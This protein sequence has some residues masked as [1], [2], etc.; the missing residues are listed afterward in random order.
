LRHAIRPR[1]TTIKNPQAN[2]ICERMHQA[3]GNSLRVLSTMQPP[4]GINAARDLVDIALADALF[5]T[6]ASLHGALK[7]TPGSIAF[8]R[9]MVLDIPFIADLQYLQ[10]H[11]QQ[12]I[13]QRLIE[14]NHK[15]YAFDYQPGQ[16]VLKLAYKPDKLAPR[17][18]GPYRIIQVHTNGTL[19]IRLNP[20]TIERISIRRVKPYKT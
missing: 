9:D 1:P 19:T 14:S 4:A 2:A 6:R 17:A 7:A 11:R 12:L 20:H 5:A 10:S 13:N 8:N 15:R 3:V 16:Q 18:Y